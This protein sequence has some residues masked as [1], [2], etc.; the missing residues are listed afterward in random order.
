[1]SHVSTFFYP[2]ESV[3]ANGYDGS[4]VRHYAE[5]MYEVRLPGG[6]A[7]VS[8]RDIAKR[9]ERPLPIL[10]RGQLDDLSDEALRAYLLAIPEAARAQYIPKGSYCYAPYPEGHPAHAGQRVPQVQWCPFFRGHQPMDTHCLINP[11]PAYRDDWG[12]NVDAVKGCGLS[13]DESLDELIQPS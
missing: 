13:E 8:A 2:G 11:K 5:N 6:V 3:R 10:S 12:F 9:P 4:I 7:C 1:M